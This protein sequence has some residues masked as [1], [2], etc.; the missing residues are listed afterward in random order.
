M[1][2]PKLLN[3]LRTRSRKRANNK[4]ARQLGGPFHLV[5]NRLLLDST[6][7]GLPY[8]RCNRVDVVEV[9]G[10][11]HQLRTVEVKAGCK[12]LG[13]VASAVGASGSISTNGALMHHAGCG[14]LCEGR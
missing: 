4:K 9:V 3:G 11:N 7:T 14:R 1:R 5:R 13:Q 6:A 8:E 12:V 2:E 10:V